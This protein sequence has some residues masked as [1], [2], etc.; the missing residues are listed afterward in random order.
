M[1]RWQSRDGPSANGQESSSG[2]ALRDGLQGE[3]VYGVNPVLGAL[4]AMRREVHVLYVQEATEG[5]KKK[6]GVPQAIAAMKERGGTIKYVSKHD[7]NLV[8]DN[9][10]HQGLML[11]CSA[12]DWEALEEFPPAD[13]AAQPD[14]GRPP[15]WLALDEIGDPQN[16]GAAVRVAYFLGVSG[17]LCCERNSAPLSPAVSKAS[18]G[19][20]EWLPLHACRSMPRTLTRA[21]ESGWHV[22]G[23]GSE[24]DAESCKGFTVS[25][26]TILVMGNEGRGLR[27]VVRRACEG[28]LRI[29]SA[30]PGPGR[31]QP[32]GVDSLNVSVATGILLH[33]LL[34]PC[35]I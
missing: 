30:A 22:V 12:L 18:A 28:I 19:A 20:L 8:T 25:R 32:L 14:S 16:L 35:T 11:D 26:P 15:V 6:E 9:K 1:Q 21:A 34:G 13:S 7:L 24:A 17:V 23:A 27:P 10:P 5:T 29:D 2:R 31:H 3:A 33:Q 4:Q